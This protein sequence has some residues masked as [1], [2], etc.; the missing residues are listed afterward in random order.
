MTKSSL[1]LIAVI[2]SLDTIRGEDVYC[3]EDDEFTLCA[4]VIPKGKEHILKFRAKPFSEGPKIKFVTGDIPFAKQ[5]GQGQCW[6][7]KR[8]V[9]AK[10]EKDFY[11]LSEIIGLSWFAPEKIKV[12]PGKDIITIIDTTDDNNRLVLTNGRSA[13][14]KRQK[15]RALDPPRRNKRIPPQVLVKMRNPLPS[16]DPYVRQ[17]ISH[18]RSTLSSDRPHAPESTSHGMPMG[19]FCNAE[20]I[21]SLDSLW[22]DLRESGG[23]VKASFFFVSPVDFFETGSK[24][25]YVTGFLPL[26]RSSPVP[27]EPGL[28]LWNV[29]RGSMDPATIESLDKT[30]EFVGK[31]T[32]IPSLATDNIHILF[33]EDRRKMTA[34]LGDSPGTPAL[35]IALTDLAQDKHRRSRTE[36]LVPEERE[37]PNGNV[38]VAIMKKDSFGG[39]HLQGEKCTYTWKETNAKRLQPTDSIATLGPV[40]GSREALMEL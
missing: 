12:C 29:E 9:S 10:D 7:P 21:G 39:T 37:L 40:L 5:R 28:S 23:L 11:G 34:L 2:A 38:C 16:G 14:W 17:G 3:Y 22:V 31:T 27:G 15:R 35:W 19:K 4:T 18:G 25:V 26:S 6:V 13:M 20:P 8:P 36:L 1:L 24:K 33:D 32:G 30:L